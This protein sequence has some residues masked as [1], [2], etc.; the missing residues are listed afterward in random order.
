MLL[1]MERVG[2]SF[3]RVSRGGESENWSRRNADGCLWLPG[4]WGHL[5]VG[6]SEW[7]CAVWL[8]VAV[9]IPAFEVNVMQRFMALPMGRAY[10]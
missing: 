2:Q 8:C 10:L 1:R 6:G 4:F 5:R 9:C 3:G 7:R